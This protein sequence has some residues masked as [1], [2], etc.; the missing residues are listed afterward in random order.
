MERSKRIAVDS[1]YFIALFNPDDALH[2]ST[3]SIAK[4]IVDEEITLVISNLIF[5]EA[6]TVISQ[7]RSRLIAIEAGNYLKYDS[8]IEIIHI[9]EALQ[10]RAWEI[11]Q[12]IQKKDVSFVDCSVIACM[13]AE[14][15][16]RLLTFD[17]KD[18][19]P[20]QK[21]FSFNFYQ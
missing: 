4:K 17:R 3:Q 1:N 14:G 19:A 21:K 12:K 9:D 2:K 16:H 5:L 18:F 20:L 13:R 6:I 11:F 8:F 7:R 10:E 15:I